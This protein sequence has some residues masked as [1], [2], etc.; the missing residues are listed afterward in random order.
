[1]VSLEA[2]PGVPNLNRI[3]RS[4]SKANERHASLCDDAKLF[5]VSFA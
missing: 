2:F 4:Y 3:H 1:M 5:H